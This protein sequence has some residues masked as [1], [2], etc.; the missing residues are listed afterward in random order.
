[1]LLFYVLMVKYIVI[2][3]AQQIHQVLILDIIGI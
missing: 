1:M 2:L 3:K